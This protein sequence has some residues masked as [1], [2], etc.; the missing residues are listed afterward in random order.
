[1]AMI[2]DPIVKISALPRTNHALSVEK[3]KDLSALLEGQGCHCKMSHFAELYIFS[4]LGGHA[5]Q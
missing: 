4:F 2:N 1:M 5:T 3:Q